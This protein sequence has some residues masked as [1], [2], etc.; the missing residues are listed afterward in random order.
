MTNSR[1]K[2]TVG[3]LGGSIRGFIRECIDASGNGSAWSVT[4]LDPE[5][6][7]L[8]RVT[9]F[10]IFRKIGELANAFWSMRKVDIVIVV[11]VGVFTP[12][13][14]RMARFWRKK[15]VYYWLG[16]DVDSLVKGKSSV[17]ICRKADF[18]LSYSEGNIAELASFGINAELLFLPSKISLDCSKMPD[19]HSVLLSI[20]DARKEFYGYNELM[21]LVALYPEVE[22]HVIRSSHPE[23]YDAPNIVFE[24][25]LDR[26]QMNEL[27]D[28]VSISI[29]WPEHDGTSL[30]LM[31]SAIK[32][33]YIIS[34]NP[35]P[36]GYITNSF[37]ELCAELERIVSI[38]P[39]P[40][41]QNREYALEHFTQGR[42][43]EKLVS[44][45]E[46]FIER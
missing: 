35:F 1:G 17:K 38:P 9:P 32:A 20:P 42:A 43:G 23:Y 45:L 28:R 15:L 12:L 4:E 5:Q 14:Y 30:I 19:R 8:S 18:N 13:Y 33:K 36:C 10:T 29:R 26:D 21:K 31:E 24:G 6:V 41:L 3:V 25:M 22:F 37:E 16:S 40:C 11:Y 46:S 27:F 44:Y 2:Y 7:K 39:M 34:R